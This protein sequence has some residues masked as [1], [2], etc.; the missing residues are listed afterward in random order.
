ML[1]LEVVV[2]AGITHNL[3]T[4]PSTE[5]PEQVSFYPKHD[6]VPENFAYPDIVSPSEINH[7]ILIPNC[8]YHRLTLHM[9]NV[10]VGR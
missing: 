2:F 8:V 6:R 3:L 9:I 7:R 1:S 10:R 4:T 5:N